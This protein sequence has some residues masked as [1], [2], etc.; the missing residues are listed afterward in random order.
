MLL[1]YYYTKAFQKR[2][3]SGNST[4]HTE[5]T[6]HRKWSDQVLRHS[7]LDWSK[8]RK[9]I[10]TSNAWGIKQY[11]IGHGWYRYKQTPQIRIPLTVPLLIQNYIGK[12]LILVKVHT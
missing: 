8:T 9:T 6:G 1:L 5:E 2:P 10:E 7:N 11:G 4:E 3:E 12:G